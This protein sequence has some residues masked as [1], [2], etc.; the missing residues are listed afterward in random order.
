MPSDFWFKVCCTTIENNFKWL[1]VIYQRD[2]P[3]FS[4]EIWGH[5]PE[6]LVLGWILRN[7]KRWRQRWH[8]G[9]VAA[10]MVSLPAKNLQWRPWR[11]NNFSVLIYSCNFWVTMRICM[12]ITHQLHGIPMVLLVFPF[13]FK[14]AKCQISNWGKL[15]M[16]LLPFL[17]EV[18]I[19]VVLTLHTLTQ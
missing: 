14:L 19:L 13:W 5:L 15:L 1:Q 2:K 7:R 17:I 6:G 16:P 12:T 18:S 11:V 10:T 9:K 3:Y 8:R 4:S